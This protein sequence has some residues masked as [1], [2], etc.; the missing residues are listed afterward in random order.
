M[1]NIL[2]SLLK[3]IILLLPGFY[4]QPAQAQEHV[5]YNNIW[6]KKEINDILT[7]RPTIDSIHLQFFQ[8]KPSK[9]EIFEISRIAM[10]QNHRKESYFY[11]LSFE[12][13]KLLLS[14]DFPS[15][16]KLVD[17]DVASAIKKPDSMSNFL[18][19][20]GK[21]YAELRDSV[22]IYGLYPIMTQQRRKDLQDFLNS[23]YNE[24]PSSFGKDSILLFQGEV[25]RGGNL[26][27][28]ELLSGKKGAFYTFFLD[29]YAYYVENVFGKTRQLSRESLI[30]PALLN[31]RPFRALIDIYVRLN[32]D[33]TISISSNGIER[34]LRIKNYKENKD[35]PLL[36]W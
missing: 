19:V 35:E 26:G 14:D 7:S 2:K 17:E 4:F 20:I 9:L 36:W 28:I 5:H 22:P 11:D 6:V 24:S 27:Q 32:P 18:L 10:K 13:D 30:K 33:N 3:I 16:K 1:V 21:N 8:N 25:D 34:R 29:N 31:G 12:G 15:I 23:K